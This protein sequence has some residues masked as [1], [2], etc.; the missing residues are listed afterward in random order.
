MPPNQ[1]FVCHGN[2]N[3]KVEALNVTCNQLTPNKTV[4]LNPSKPCEL[5]QTFLTGA[6]T[7]SD[8]ASA[9]KI[10]SGHARLGLIQVADIQKT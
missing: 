2:Y 10:G 5:S 3:T 9:Q 4:G 1:H 7:E 6:Y 8:N